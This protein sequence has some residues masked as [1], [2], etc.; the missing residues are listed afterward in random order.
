MAVKCLLNYGNEWPWLL[1][2][3]EV[4][5]YMWPFMPKLIVSIKTKE[6]EQH[7]VNCKTTFLTDLCCWFLKFWFFKAKFYAVLTPYGS[8]D[9][10]QSYCEW[11]MIAPIE[12]WYSH[13]CKMWWS[14]SMVTLYTLY[15]V[16]KVV[17]FPNTTL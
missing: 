14:Y 7:S 3:L 9:K 11:R 5:L 13:P 10:I 4:L 8:S 16:T 1:A 6:K 12:I 2:Q 15:F 17:I